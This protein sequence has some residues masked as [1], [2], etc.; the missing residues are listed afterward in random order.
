MV[1]DVTTDGRERSVA[2][3]LM[4]ASARALNLF[5]RMGLGASEP[6]TRRALAA[7]SK[8]NSDPLPALREKGGIILLISDNYNKLTRPSNIGKAQVRS[9]SCPI[10]CSSHRSLM[11]HPVSCPKILKLNDF[12]SS[13]GWDWTP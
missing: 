4:G 2:F 6:T 13:G 7:T 8:N 9:V 3:S 12:V 11:Y 10:D 5:A 1:A